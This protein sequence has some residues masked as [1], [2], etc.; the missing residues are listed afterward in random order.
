MPKQAD[1]YQHITL[2]A[3]DYFGPAAPRFVS[4]IIQSHLGKEPHEVMISDMPAFTT[5]MK[6]TVAMVTDETS[7]VTELTQR[8]DKLSKVR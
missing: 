1:L 2:I 3:E 4:R 6:L 5:W 8:L 7:V